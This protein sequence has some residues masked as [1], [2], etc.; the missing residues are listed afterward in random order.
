MSTPK[1]IQINISTPCSQPWEQMTP[2]AEGRH[3]AHCSK[4]VVDF[5]TW[6][7]AALY[8]FFSQNTDRVCGRFFATQLSR[9]LYI[10]PQPHSRLYRITIALGLTLIFTQ[11]TE[12]VAQNKA[13]RATQSIAKLDVASTAIVTRS[14]IIGRI[15]DEFGQP[16]AGLIVQIKT[17][18]TLVA[19]SSSDEARRFSLKEIDTG[20][21]SLLIVHERFTVEGENQTPLHTAAGLTDLRI[22]ITR[23][24]A[25]KSMKIIQAIKRYRGL[26]TS[27]MREQ[28]FV[29]GES[30]AQN[31]KPA[32]P[33]PA[34]QRIVPEFSANKHKK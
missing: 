10:P 16:L 5:T 34:K 27:I 15:K 2:D 32:P 6:G 29:T 11:A 24:N 14:K 26:E 21:Y 33:A 12:V 18:E 19:S 3:C 30:E 31:I 22:Y 25:A 4:T 1:P 17:N 23:N 9:P 8:N 13:P 7:D 20:N 28:V